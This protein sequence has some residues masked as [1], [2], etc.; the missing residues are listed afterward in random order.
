M[1]DTVVVGIPKAEQ[2]DDAARRA[3]QLAAMCRAHLH[4]VHAVA[5]GISAPDAP[6]RRHAE[7]LLA[8][9]AALTE[10][11]TTCHTLPGDPA[12]VLLQVAREVGADLIVVG[13]K[14]MGGAGR[15]LGSVPNAVAHRASCS[16]LILDT[17]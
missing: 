15:V 12:D 8:S 1:F 9:L 17:F 11:E 2:A 14:G 3:A 6:E 7:Q 5:P 16:V 10:G 4:L 13:N